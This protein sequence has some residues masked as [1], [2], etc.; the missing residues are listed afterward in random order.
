[1]KRFLIFSFMIL[2]GHIAFSQSHKNDPTYSENNYK[3]PNK[4]AWAREH[5][6]DKSNEFA[7]GKVEQNDNYK[8]QFNQAK[9]SEKAIVKTKSDLNK[10][11]KSYK[12]PYGL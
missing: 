12:H 2:G 11:R 6:T 5:K 10:S 3:H 1:M 8:Q 4:A 7:T 9:T